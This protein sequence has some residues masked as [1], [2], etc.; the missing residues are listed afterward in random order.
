MDMGNVENTIQNAGAPFGHHIL[1]LLRKSTKVR[2]HGAAKAP[3][4][5]ERL[6]ATKQRVLAYICVV[7]RSR[8]IAGVDRREEPRR[9]RRIDESVQKLS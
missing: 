5:V 3:T 6:G 9:S 1:T 2:Y 4:K 7:H 8:Q